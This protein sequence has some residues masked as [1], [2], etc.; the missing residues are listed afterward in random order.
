MKLNL[1]VE[2]VATTTVELTEEEHIAL[3]TG[4][5][6][7]ERMFYADCIFGRANQ[8]IDRDDIGGD[9]RL[10]LLSTGDQE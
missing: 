4:A 1:S 3:L 6:T 2:V 10:E 7:L 9:A 5:T 8:V